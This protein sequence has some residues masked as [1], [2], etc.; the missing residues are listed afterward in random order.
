MTYL[1]TCIMNPIKFKT[2]QSTS[3]TSCGHLCASQNRAEKQNVIRI[4]R[5]WNAG[6][7]YKC[8]KLGNMKYFTKELHCGL[9]RTHPPTHIARRL[10]S[11]VG[12]QARLGYA[13][14]DAES[15]FCHYT[16]RY[17][18]PI[19]LCVLERSPDCGSGGTN[20]IHSAPNMDILPTH[21]KL[22]SSQR[23]T[24]SHLQQRPLPDTD[25]KVTSEGRPYLGAALGTEEYIQ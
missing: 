7:A 20:S 24:V 4:S 13:A 1:S 19:S 25:V 6:N 14:F 3:Y 11:C 23:R 17:T 16:V 21:A 10:Q 18:V 12:T 9:Q 2:S 15:L 8:R 5:L 22:G